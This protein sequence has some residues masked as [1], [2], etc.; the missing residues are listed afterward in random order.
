MKFT[1]DMKNEDGSVRFNG[2]ATKEQASFLMEVGVNYLLQRGVE[3]ML[4]EK[5]ATEEV[6]PTVQ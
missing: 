3:P 4:G 1:I 5:K 2:T 6:S